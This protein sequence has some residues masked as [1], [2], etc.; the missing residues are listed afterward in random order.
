LTGSDGPPLARSPA[1]EDDAAVEDDVAVEDDEAADDEATGDDE[2]DGAVQPASTPQAARP[3]HVTAPRDRNRRRSA[4][5]SMLTHQG[6]K[7]VNAV[8]EIGKPRAGN[9]QAS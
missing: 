5:S 1:V 9:R 8:R 4:T 3:A 6:R 2:D 7:P